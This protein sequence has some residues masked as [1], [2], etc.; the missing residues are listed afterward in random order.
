MDGRA[1]A[2]GGLYF[3]K[4]TRVDCQWIEQ[5]KFR[6]LA[7]NLNINLFHCQS[8]NGIFWSLNAKYDLASQW[9]Y[10]KFTLEH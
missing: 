8:I 7:L 1:V 6:C 9:T 2:G 3:R 10:L 4:D 5:N